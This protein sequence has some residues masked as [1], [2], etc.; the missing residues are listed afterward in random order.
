MKILDSIIQV[1]KRLDLLGRK[2]NTVNAVL[3]DTHDVGFDVITHDWEKARLLY[4]EL[5]R[6]CHPDKFSDGKKVIATK[7][8][9]SL[10]ANKYNYPILLEIKRKA[11]N[12]LNISISSH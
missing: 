3:E 1:A 5:K 4:N 7:I 9:Q 8:F 12:E 2:R 11:V 10:V 6:E